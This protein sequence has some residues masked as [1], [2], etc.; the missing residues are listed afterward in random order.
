[1]GQQGSCRICCA[2]YGC[3]L[4]DC[5]WNYIE[6]PRSYDAGE[7]FPGCVADYQ[8]SWQQVE[9]FYTSVDMKYN[10][11]STSS[12]ATPCVLIPARR[13]LLISCIHHI[14]QRQDVA[15]GNPFVYHDIDQ[16]LVRQRRGSMSQ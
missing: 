16:F 14:S 8:V 1:M 2:Y 13:R 10:S 6:H 4:E 15:T 9:Q 12:I 7:L 11:A 5:V 3:R